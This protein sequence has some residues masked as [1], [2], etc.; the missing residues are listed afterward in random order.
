MSRLLLGNLYTHDFGGD[1]APISDSMA[2]G[3]AAGSQAIMWFAQSSDVIVLPQVPDPEYVAYLTTMM[4]VDWASLRI[5]VPPAA[6]SSP[7]FL[8]R[9][10][11]TSAA[12]LAELRD[13]LAG[14]TV[15]QIVALMPDAATAALATELGCPDALPGHRFFSQGG[16]LLA[17]SKACFRA[18]AAGSGAPLPPGGVARGKADAK[19]L[20]VELLEQRHPVILKRDFGGGGMGS[21]V[22]ALE[23]ILHPVGAQRAVHLPNIDHLDDY[24]CERWDWLTNGDRFPVVIERYY[25][26]AR[27]IFAEF[28]IAD[29]AV[30]FEEYGEII[31]APIAFAEFVPAPDVPSDA[32]G[33]LMVA[34]HAL[35]EGLQAAGYRNVVSLDAI[36]LESGEVLFTEWNGRITA[37]T[38]I[39]R[40]IGRRLVGSDFNRCR[41]LGEF[42]GWQVPSFPAAV[43]RL[44]EA[45]MHYDRA[46]RTGVVLVKGFNPEDSTVRYCAV[47]ESAQAATQMSKKVEGLFGPDI[48]LK[49]SKA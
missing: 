21:E 41:V 14:R 8:T 33:R 16:A 12:G 5:V 10:R 23:A 35:A 9:D 38:H 34:G 27:A 6:G 37:S 26:R 1:V 40:N 20:I 32:L 13:A 25:R 48:Q 45:G 28:E 46:T 22:V 31:H 42:V 30:S 17:N 29:D 47:A 15:D 3:V 36:L 24:L 4:G 2:R 7:Y 44:D 43:A 49:R 18:I 19:S 39:Y 11:L